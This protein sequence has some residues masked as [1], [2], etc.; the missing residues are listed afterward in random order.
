MGVLANSLHSIFPAAT[1]ERLMNSNWYDRRDDVRPSHIYVAFDPNGGG[2]SHSAIVAL[3]RIE[4]TLLVC[5]MDSLQTYDTTQAKEFIVWFVGQL[6]LDPWLKHARIIY[7]CENNGLTFGLM[8][9]VMAGVPNSQT[10]Y[11]KTGGKPGIFTDSYKKNMYAEYL[12]QELNRDSV[13]FLRN[14]ITCFGMPAG[15]KQ[16]AHGQVLS[17]ADKR[18]IIRRE[19]FEQTKRAKPNS[20][21]Y[22][23]DLRPRVISW[24]AKCNADGDIV[25]GMNDDLL[26][27]L[28]IGLYVL[29][30]YERNDSAYTA[31]QWGLPGE[32]TD[33]APALTAMVH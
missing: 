15:G 24:S 5:G 28:C 2:P 23:T 11:E 6:R 17:E 33:R 27:V 7:A 20:R 18:I 4:G 32:V 21:P 25:Q 16:T 9:E 29:R 12:R 30:Q 14:F 8:E 10:V 19:L 26:L 22:T 13:R 1:S 31:M 3:V